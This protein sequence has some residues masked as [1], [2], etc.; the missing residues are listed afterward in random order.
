LYLIFFKFIK[1]IIDAVEKAGLSLPEDAKRTSLYLEWL[2]RKTKYFDM[3][4]QPVEVPY[5]VFP[6]KITQFA[7]SKNQPYVQDLIQKYYSV[8]RK[9]TNFIANNLLN[10]DAQDKRILL[11]NLVLLRG[12]VVWVDFGFNIGCEFG[13]KHPAVI[14]KNI[15]EV[16]IVTPI[17]S[18]IITKPRQF[19]VIIDKVYNFSIRDRYTNITRITPISIYRVDLHSPI[20]SIRS[21]NLKAIL[22]AIN[23]EWHFSN[24]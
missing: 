17:T 6:L 20:G 9:T 18:G 7:Y 5:T 14:L 13:G 1:S 23:V 12:N 19:E 11:H 4:K 8:E 22:E 2:E 10:I 15:G 3:E 24:E 21:E 16:L